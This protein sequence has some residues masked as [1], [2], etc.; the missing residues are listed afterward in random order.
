MKKLK[1]NDKIIRLPAF[2]PDATH[3]A[4]KSVGSLD[5]IRENVSGIVVNTYHLLVDKNIETVKKLGGVHEFTK[6]PGI[7]ITDSGGFQAMSLIRRSPGNGKITEDGVYFHINGNKILLSPELCIKTQLEAGSDIIMCLDDCTD[8]AEAH[9]E[10]KLSVERTVRWAKRC[11][12]YFDRKTNFGRKTKNSKKKPLIFGIVQGGSSKKLRKECAD[13][14]IKIGFDGYA[15]GG[16]PVDGTGKFLSEIVKFTASV[17]PDDK[18]KYAMGVGKPQDI[19]ECIRYG[20]NL[21]DCVLPTRDARHERLYVFSGRSYK[22]IYIGSG[23]YK[24]DN[25]P[26]SGKCKCETCTSYSRA[27]LYNLFKN[28]DPLALRLA[29][30]HNLRFYTDL[31]KLFN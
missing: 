24:K 9:K 23:K 26:I 31:M 20:Y 22:F 16:W 19:K 21:F 17:M 3:G 28:K 1:I 12:D 14:L 8:P 27:Y 18:P 15:Y 5:L 30:I 4:V 10:Q 29:T 2:F 7:I 13:G 11:K 25:K 6:F